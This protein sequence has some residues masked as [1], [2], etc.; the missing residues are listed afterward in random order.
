LNARLSLQKIDLYQNLQELTDEQ[1]FGNLIRKSQKYH[2]PI[3]LFHS[4][5]QNH[6]GLLQKF[7]FFCKYEGIYQ[8]IGRQD[9]TADVN[10][11]DLMHWSHGF[12]SRQKCE[13]QREFLLPHA[14]SSHRGDVYAMDPLGAGSAFRVWHLW[15]QE[16]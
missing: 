11:S 14:N 13:T 15:K 4:W 2:D 16:S 10:F 12:A 5:F 8:N 3:E 1:H 9:L 6:R 7:G